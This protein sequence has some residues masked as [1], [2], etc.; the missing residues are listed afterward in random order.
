LLFDL[1]IVLYFFNFVYI[2]GLSERKSINHRFTI[3]RQI[4]SALSWYSLCLQLVKSQYSTDSLE[5]VKYAIILVI[6]AY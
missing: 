2:T 4:Y 5:S 1:H 6:G 3:K